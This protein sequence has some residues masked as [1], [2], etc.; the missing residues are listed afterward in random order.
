[1]LIRYS[2]P[3]VRPPASVAL[4]L[5]RSHP[6]ARGL[7]GLF[8]TGGQFG[9]GRDMVTGALLSGT[10]APTVGLTPDGP[11][12]DLS[13]TAFASAAHDPIWNVTGPLTVAWRG[14]VRSNAH[15]FLVG[16]APVS[17]NGATDTPF[18]LEYG[19]PTADKVLLV[20]SSGP[21]F[22]YRAWQSAAA[23]L[24]TNQITTVSVSAGAAI[25]VAPV[26]YF[27]GILDAGA[28]TNEHGGTATGAPN[29]NTA[30]IR[31]GRRADNVG[32]QDGQT[33]IIALASRQW[34]ADEHE[35]FAADPW[36]L[37][38]DAP[39]WHFLGRA[40]ATGYTLAADQ[41]GFSLS[42]QTI[43]LKAGRRVVADQGSFALTGQAIS[44]KHGRRLGADHGAFSLSGQGISLEFGRR[45]AA[46]HGAF[47]L[48]GQDV[49]FRR[50][51]SMAIEAGSFGL[52]GQDLRLLVGRRITLTHGAFTLTGQAIDFLQAEAEP[53]GYLIIEVLS[54]TFQD[55]EI[56]TDSQGGAAL[57]LG[58]VRYGD[59]LVDL[60]GGSIMNMVS[61]EWLQSGASH[62]GALH[63]VRLE[64]VADTLAFGD[65]WAY[66]LQ[67]ASGDWATGGGRIM[68]N[69]HT[70]PGNALFPRMLLRNNHMDAYGGNGGIA[71]PGSWEDQGF[72]G[73]ADGIGL[74][75]SA[76]SDEGNAAV[77]RSL[78][79]W[80]QEIT[81]DATV[82]RTTGKSSLKMDL[83]PVYTGGA[84]L[85]VYLPVSPGKL[86]LDEFWYSKPSGESARTLGPYVSG[87]PTVDDTILVSTQEGRSLVS[88]EDKH[89]QWIGGSGP[90]P[91]WTVTLAG[92]T[93]DPGGILNAVWNGTHT[94]V[95]RLSPF[96]YSI[97]LGT[98]NEA[99]TAVGGAGGAAIEATYSQTSV[100]I[101][102][103][104]FWVRRMG[105]DSVGRPVIA[106]AQYQGEKN[107][108]VTLATQDWT[109]WDRG[110]WYSENVIPDSLDDRVARGRAPE[111][112]SHYML[113]LNWQN[114]REANL[115]TPPAL[116]LTDFYANVI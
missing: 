85:R 98:G 113:V 105:F 43:N 94:V 95:E 116:H 36:F 25:E 55:G 110:T 46:A 63:A 80:E 100:L 30:P 108:E 90:R 56:L 104:T 2:R 19:N 14:I 69:N 28:P 13:G 86:V 15:G 1:V 3:R 59:Y 23:L 111:W 66:N 76:H 112:A 17:G 45:L 4:R 10:S 20:R 81:A 103:R 61:G 6:L 96:R 50:G 99:D 8:V 68:W 9:L 31:F 74:D 106:Q 87:V 22:V 32:Q 109:R 12:L 71:G 73:P 91:G 41:G 34:S 75:F 62:R 47:S 102:V 7:V 24:P 93:G 5:R 16:K 115:T 79:P 65:V 78:V 58:T 72:T 107:I 11:A 82:F 52:A 48:T 18:N 39:L 92:V 26:F 64:S 60:R 49:I 21:G 40:V 70:G 83:N 38:E 42:G 27:N 54:G 53:G 57:A 67:T 29:S 89:A 33:A 44:L 97:D 114:I 51:R 88:V 84:E 37:L 35:M 77:S 101:F